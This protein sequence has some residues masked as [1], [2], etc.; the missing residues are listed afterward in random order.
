MEKHFIYYGT[1]ENC[2]ETEKHET[3]D[4]SND[5]KSFIDTELGEEDYTEEER[6]E[7][8]NDIMED[9]SRYGYGY[10]EDTNEQGYEFFLGVA[11][12]GKCTRMQLL[13]N[14]KRDECMAMA[15]L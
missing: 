5:V 7:I 6:Q 2:F 12:E 11:K 15:G 8:V 1:E 13:L 9:V 10:Y 4:V 3:N 14:E